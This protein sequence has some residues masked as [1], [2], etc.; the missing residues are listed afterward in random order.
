MIIFDFHCMYNFHC[1]RIFASP[2]LK[3]HHKPN[4]IWIVFFCSDFFSA[5][6]TKGR[7]LRYAVRIWGCWSLC[8]LW[9]GFF[10]WQSSFSLCIMFLQSHS[11]G[12]IDAVMKHIESLLQEGYFFSKSAFRAELL[13]RYRDKIGFHPYFPL[14]PAACSVF[15]RNS[16][17]P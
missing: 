10:P 17:D 15:F 1:N 7:I 9:G 16:H 8:V 4:R 5:P 2:T 13:I 3:K 11:F 12:L 6:R 14:F